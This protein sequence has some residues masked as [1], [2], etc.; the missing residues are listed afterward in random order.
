MNR[1]DADVETAGTSEW[2]SA[3]Y[4]SDVADPA[5]APAISVVEVLTGIHR[6]A[7]GT[8]TV[9]YVQFTGDRFVSLLGCV[10]NT[11]VEVAQ[12]LSLDTAVRRLLLA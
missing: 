8:T 6:V 10:Y 11:S 12:T 9:G 7:L 3:T 5:E 2:S 4:M 1:A